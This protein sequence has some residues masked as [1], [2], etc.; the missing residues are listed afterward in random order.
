[1]LIVKRFVEN[2]R[3]V[4]F[5]LS[6]FDEIVNLIKSLE[7][8]EENLNRKENS[9]QKS[10]ATKINTNCSKTKA[11][12]PDLNSGLDT[13]SIRKEPS[14]LCLI[15]EEKL[16]QKA[17]KSSSCD[18][19]EAKTTKVDKRKTRSSNTP[20][21]IGSAFSFR[22]KKGSLL[23]SQ[24]SNV[25]ELSDFVKEKI[26]SPAENEAISRNLRSRSRRCKLN[27]IT[28]N[29]EPKNVINDKPPLIDEISESQVNVT[30]IDDSP[31]ETTIRDD[32]RPFII[33]PDILKQANVYQMVSNIGFAFVQSKEKNFF[34]CFRPD[35]SFTSFNENVFIE[36]LNSKHENVIWNRFCNTCSTF[37]AVNRKRN[38]LAEMKHLKTCHVKF[39]FECRL[40]SCKNIDPVSAQ[41]HNKS[42]TTFRNFSVSKMR[43]K[44]RKTC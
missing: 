19:K 30:A 26:L 5:S 38:L 13:V 28:E 20:S 1:M 36:H 33:I 6:V 23:K 27:S 37:V 35:C 10:K 32:Q 42:C 2:V 39:E 29:D 17:P 12:T 22:I 44:K 41:S 16:K 43:S 11:V 40:G 34:K 3:Y 8:S 24:H 14:R 15:N 7:D 9:E 31:D 18:Q 21:T 4:S 25:S